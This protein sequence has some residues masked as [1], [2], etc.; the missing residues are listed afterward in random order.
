MVQKIHFKNILGQTLSNKL[1][2]TFYIN[3]KIVFILIDDEIYNAQDQ[4]YILK[5]INMIKNE[6]EYSL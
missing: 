4:A 6:C 2:Y 3:S 5:F 1:S